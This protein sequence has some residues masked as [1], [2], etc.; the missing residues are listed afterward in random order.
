MIIAALIII[1]AVLG[2]IDAQIYRN[3]TEPRMKH[4]SLKMKEIL[5]M[6]DQINKEKNKQ[7]TKRKIL[8]KK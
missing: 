2:H 3:F 5:D 7:K 1:A 6:Y 8:L 4:E